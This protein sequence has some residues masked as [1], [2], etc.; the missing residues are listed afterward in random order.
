[1]M[2]FFKLIAATVMNIRKLYRDA[3]SGK[4]TSK[5]QVETSPDTTV[6]ETRKMAQQPQ[7]Q[8]GYIMS[9]LN[10]AENHITAAKASIEELR[11]VVYGHMGE[12]KT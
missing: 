5:E 7:V 12:K 6:T 1:M 10:D 4:F 11:A 9:R 3:I 8:W 2:R